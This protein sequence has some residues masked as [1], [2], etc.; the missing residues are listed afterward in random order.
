MLEQRIRGIAATV[1]GLQKLREVKAVGTE[2]GTRLTYEGIADRIPRN[3]QTSVDPI[4]VRRF[5]N[6]ERID[7]DSVT[8]ICMALGLEVTEIVDPNE[9]HPTK[10]RQKTQSVA[11]SAILNTTPPTVDEWQGREAEMNELQAALGDKKLVSLFIRAGRKGYE[12]V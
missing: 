1:A 9:W 12:K 8:A 3:S 7:R 6:G 10:P 4:T 2:D 11:T 5:F